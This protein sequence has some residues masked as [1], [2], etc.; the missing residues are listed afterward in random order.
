[1]QA[2]LLVARTTKALFLGTFSDRAADL[3]DTVGASR[4]TVDLVQQR[5]R[6]ARRELAHDPNGASGNVASQ[7]RLRAEIVS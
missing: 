6:N 4:E 5:D 1:V 2:H 7:S 3:G